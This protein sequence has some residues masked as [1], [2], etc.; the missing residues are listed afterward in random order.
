MGINSLKPYLELLWKVVPGADTEAIFGATSISIIRRPQNINKYYV[1]LFSLKS[2][3]PTINDLLWPFSEGGEVPLYIIN[4][5]GSTV[6]SCG[7]TY[8]SL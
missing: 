2:V 1:I 5:S 7:S 8:I 4:L 3:S 6:S